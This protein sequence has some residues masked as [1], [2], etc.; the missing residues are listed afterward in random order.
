MEFA[1]PQKTHKWFSL[2]MEWQTEGDKKK[3]NDI[4]DFS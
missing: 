2:S 4:K 3:N 1:G